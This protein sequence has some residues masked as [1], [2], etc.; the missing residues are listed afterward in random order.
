MH[1]IIFPNAEGRG[2]LSKK[3]RRFIELSLIR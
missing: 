2:R 1:K 3:N